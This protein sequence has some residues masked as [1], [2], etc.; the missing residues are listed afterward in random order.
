V[1]YATRTDPGRFVVGPRW[2]KPVRRQ[3]LATIVSAA[4][5]VT[6][7]AVVVPL[8]ATP[9]SAATYTASGSILKPSPGGNP[10]TD[11]EFSLR[12]CPAMPSQQGLDAYVFRLPAEY[13]VAGTTVSLKGTDS[14]GLHDLVAY[15]YKADC[16]YD[17]V[18][19][20]ASS[21]E[22]TI[23]LANGDTFL[24]VFTAT[25]SEVAVDLAATNAAVVTPSSTSP[26]SGT[27]QVN[28]NGTRRSYPATPNDPLYLQDGSTDLFFGGQWGMRKV[29]ATEAWAQGRSTGAGI[30]VAVLDS[31]LDLGHPE[32]ACADKVELVPGADPDNDGKTVPQDDVEGHGT[33]VAGIVG[34]CSNNGTGVIGV[35]PDST[36]LPIQVLSE[37]A[38]AAIL[39][40]AIRTA[41]DQGAH[42]INMSLGAGLAPGGL[43]QVPGS[44][45]A[46]AYA[47]FFADVDAAIDYA[48]S[49]G[50]IVVAAAGNESAPLCGYPAISYNVICVGASD[51]RDLNS[52]YGNFPVKDDDEDLVGPAL[53]APGGTGIPDCAWASS[54]ILSTY[55]RSVDASEGDCDGMPGYATIFGTSMATPLVAGTAAL[56]YDRIGGMRSPANAAKVTEALLET[57][58]DLY[59]PGYDPASGEG[60]LDALAAVKY[61]PAAPLTNSTSTSVTPSQ[62][63]SPTPTETVKPAPKKTSVAIAQGVPATVQY[64]DPLALSATL[65]SDGVPVAGESVTFQLQ[66]AQGFREVSATTGE[67]GVASASLPANTPPGDYRVVVG[68]AGKTDTYDSSS[69]SQ[70]IAVVRE[71]T[72]TV[73]TL[74]GTGSKRTLTAVVAEADD[75]ASRV[76]GVTVTLWADGVQAGSA[77]TDGTGTAAFTPKNAKVYE[78]RFGGDAFYAPSSGR[79]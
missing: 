72:T 24:S 57:A 76:A 75:A 21:R 31:G 34:A 78:V 49:K 71:D 16:T 4:V 20:D 40:T 48:V 68:Y 37:T 61:W 33:H 47:G 27:G 66:G 67:N 30:R 29:R 11:A 77:V 32:F 8:L 69:A 74:S 70:P 53:L 13:A 42:V 50:V 60:R 14:L 22:L 5:A 26:T 28:T 62:T 10:A 64:G 3:L 39:A 56:V 25:G 46:V 2:E 43:V 1:A 17:R 7:A 45:S 79:A 54:E 15:V 52:W 36:I 38:D 41:T 51:P 23:A 35:A 19:S 63:V 18:V 44:G 55:S 9:A 58:V 12:T 6:T 73:A 65:T 59:A